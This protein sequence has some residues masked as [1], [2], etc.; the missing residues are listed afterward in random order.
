MRDAS[1]GRN[2]RGRT[3]SGCLRMSSSMTGIGGLFGSPQGYANST[4][5]LSAFLDPLSSSLLGLAAGIAQVNTPSPVRQPIGNVIGSAAGGFQKGGLQA[6]QRQKL[7]TQ[8]QQASLPAKLALLGA[9]G[10]VSIPTGTAGGNPS[11]GSL[12]VDATGDFTP[13]GGMGSGGPSGGSP[14]GGT[15]S[16][17]AANRQL[18]C[19]SCRRRCLNKPIGSPSRTKMTEPLRRRCPRCRAWL[20]EPA[21]RC[22]ATARRISRRGSADPNVIGTKAY[23]EASGTGRGGP[24]ARSRWP[25]SRLGSIRR[26]WA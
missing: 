7:Q 4:G 13:G 3:T 15:S 2:G 8:L 14:P 18:A 20:E 5:G 21:I 11:G 12:S 24:Q 9:G 16:G 26:T 22:R 10:L 17:G 25:T 1:S 19:L 6:L 23:A